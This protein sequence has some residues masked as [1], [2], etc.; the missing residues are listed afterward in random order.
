MSEVKEQQELQKIDQ[1][2][3]K[4]YLQKQRKL[5]DD[6]KQH[7]DSLKSAIDQ[8]L[9]SSASANINPRFLMTPQDLAEI[10]YIQN[11]PELKE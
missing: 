2:K 5:I 1:E 11:N 10:K 3:L 8:Q 9:T 6:N 7:I 4:R